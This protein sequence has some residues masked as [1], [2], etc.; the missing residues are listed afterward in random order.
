RSWTAVRAALISPSS[1]PIARSMAEC[2]SADMPPLASRVTAKAT[3][4]TPAAMTTAPAIA[5][6]LATLASELVRLRPGRRIAGDPDVD[7]VL[8]GLDGDVLGDRRLAALAP[9]LEL[10]LARRQ[11]PEREAAFVV[12]DDV[13]RCGDHG[14]VC[15]HVGVE[16]TAQPHNAFL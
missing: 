16:V 14:D 7:L 5:K 2:C 11:V 15:A 9:G 6:P 8:A 13:G 1:V 10:V 3:A 4:A 12:G